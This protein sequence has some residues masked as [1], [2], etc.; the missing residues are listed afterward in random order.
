MSGNAANTGLRLPTRLVQVTSIYAIFTNSVSTGAYVVHRRQSVEGLIPVLRTARRQI[1]ALWG[2]SSRIPFFG[3]PMT[4]ALS[5]PL[6]L[7]RG[8][9]GIAGVV[10]AASSKTEGA[11]SK[12]AGP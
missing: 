1:P 7:F 9:R 3:L 2:G 11:S 10:V 5:C 8:I 6:T 12:P 4:C